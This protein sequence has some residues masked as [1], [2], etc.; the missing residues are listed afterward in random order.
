MA[1]T[2]QPFRVYNGETSNVATKV[3]GGD[4]S[5]IRDWDN[6][7]YPRMLEINKELFAEYWIEDEVKLGKDLEDYKNKLSDEERKVYNYISGKLNWLDS[8]ATDFNFVLGYLC[9]DPSVRSNIALICSF[10]ELHNRSYQYLTST[11]L[12]DQQKKQAFEDVRKIPQLVKRN[13]LVIDKIQKL[14]DI[15]K[16]H[17]DNNLP[18]SKELLQVIFEGILANLVLEGLYFSGGFAYFHSLARDNKMIESNNMINLI[19][20]DETQHNVFFGMLMQILMKEFPELNTKENMK[21]A[22]NFIRKAVELEKEWA[23]FI[24]ANIDTLSIKE[25]HD[26]VEYLANVICRNAGIEEVYPENTELKS[27][28]I[29]TYGSKKRNSADQI[30]SRTDFLQGNAI[31]YTHESGED[32]DL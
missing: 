25:Y 9:T 23:N 12:N 11:M 30:V 24:F 19:K 8:M 22:V 32:F 3:F 6:V 18:I 15:A 2:V 10:E 21:F 20:T 14:V 31:N 26:Y 16:Y 17:I 13:E 29:I 28:W 5:G 1:N 4:A 27:K 7:K